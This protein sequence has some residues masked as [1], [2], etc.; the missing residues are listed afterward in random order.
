MILKVAK[1]LTT[2]SQ[3]I[4]LALI[5]G[6]SLGLAVGPQISSLVSH[7]LLFGL[8]F[9]I[10]IYR[11]RSVISPIVVSAFSIV[12]LA[13][14]LQLAQ[15]FI[16]VRVSFIWLSV[17][18]FLGVTVITWTWRIRDEC[19]LV[20]I[21]VLQVV[22]VSA[23]VLFL[24]R[25]VT[26]DVREALI[27]V[28]ATQEDNGTWLDGIAR[29]LRRDSAIDPADIV[30]GGY[31]GT[32]VASLLVGTSVL[33]HQVTGTP[34]DSALLTLQMYWLLT[35]CAVFIAARITFILSRPHAG[36]LAAV[37]ATLTALLT[38]LFA[39][40]L[41]IVGHLTALL[42]ATLLMVTLLFLLEKPFLTGSNRV[43]SI[44]MLWGVASAWYPMYGLLLLVLGVVFSNSVLKICRLGFASENFGLRVKLWSE[45]RSR[46]DWFLLALVGVVGLVAMRFLV[47]PVAKSILDIQYLT[48]Q[49]SLGGAYASVHPYLILVIFGLAIGTL[50]SSMGNGAESAL[51]KLMVLCSVA[52]PTIFVG[53]GFFRTPYEPQYAAYKSLQL[54]SMVVISIAIAGLVRAAIRLS[55]STTYSVV[56]IAV[57]IL[58]G[59]VTY[60]E[61]YP[62]VRNLMVAPE[63]AWWVNAASNELSE[64]PDRLLVCLDTR[65]KDWRGYDAYVCTRQLAGIQ[66]RTSYET[67][68]WTAANICQV[69]SAQMAA[70]PVEFWR[71]L[72]ILV[73]DKDR[74]VNSNH[75]DGF[76]WAGPEMPNDEQYPIGWLS[77]VPWREV[78]VIDQDGNA[79]KK[80]FRYLKD[81]TGF[82]DEIIEQLERTLTS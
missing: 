4:L 37:P 8:G 12:V 16:E 1:P 33:L 48:Y 58:I 77:S 39:R 52:L 3:Q 15:N 68:T 66:G 42:A 61:P 64:N 29:T 56:A 76:G 2:V 38:F 31:V 78:R 50:A 65:S 71:K 62:Q 13:L 28:S 17:L 40:S 41:H 72:T 27:A 30:I 63:G 69:S 19:Q 7:H 82:T 45:S 44:L 36:Y 73:T 57:V 22:L 70:I 10:V 5:A 24:N 51:F 53:L 43:L 32:V 6:V 35:V 75:C 14:T 81:E 18:F 23:L 55:R 59:G 25:L 79:V 9:S 80:S 34:G 60:M 54:V 21:D 47:W 49:L 20:W 74:L 26:W 67:N 11:T 46:L